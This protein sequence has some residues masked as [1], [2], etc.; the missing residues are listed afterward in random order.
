MFSRLAGAASRGLV[1]AASTADLVVSATETIARRFP[2]SRTV[3]VRNYPPLRDAEA[4]PGARDVRSRP[5]SAVYVGGLTETRGARVMVDAF[6]EEALPEGWRLKLAG[7]ATAPLIEKLWAS[8]GWHRVDYAGQVGSEEARDVV[9]GS[10]VG[11]VLLADIPSYRDSLP[12]KMFEYFAAG[13]PVVASDFPL[14]RSI[15]EENDCGLLVDPTSPAQVAEAL[16]AYA[17]DPDLL[18]RHS[19]NARRLAVEKLN[20]Q[21]EAATLV[22]AY[23]D[24]SRR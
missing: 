20:W 23:G 4:G 14:W 13:V 2:A 11:L 17:E 1:R 10:R 5:L 7:S 12:T 21:P 6:G 22:A 19:R 16:R 9:L 24:L 18:S 8:R 15:V 3:V